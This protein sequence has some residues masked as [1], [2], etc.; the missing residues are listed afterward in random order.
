MPP[1]IVAM[2]MR[3]GGSSPRLWAVLIFIGASGPSPARAQPASPQ[4]APALA[5]RSPWV[6]SGLAFGATV[7]GWAIGAV[8]GD[9]DQ[10]ASST[11]GRLGLGL[12]FAVSAIGP[13]A[14]HLYAGEGAHALRWSLIRA[15]GLGVGVAGVAL[16]VRGYDRDRGYAFPS[17]VAGALGL[18]VYAAGLGWDLY[19]AHRATARANRR[20]AAPVSVIVTPML[21]SGSGLQLSGTF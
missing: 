8:A 13:S 11:L 4:A 20:A 16:A 7:G 12:S 5:H 3:F 18:G 1:H 6:A 17:A 2:T 15:G 10:D 21:G 14:G 9:A 19:D